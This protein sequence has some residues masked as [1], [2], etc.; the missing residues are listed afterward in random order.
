MSTDTIACLGTHSTQGWHRCTGGCA[1]HS[2]SPH[3]NNTVRG[4][5]KPHY[6]PILVLLDTCNGT[7]NPGKL[8]SFLQTDGVFHGTRVFLI[9]TIVQAGK[10]R[11]ME[12]REAGFPLSSG[13]SVA[14][15]GQKIR[16]LILHSVIH[17]FIHSH[18][19]KAAS[20][21]NLE[22]DLEQCRAQRLPQSHSTP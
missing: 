20:Q 6:S 11:S 13:K 2:Q 18:P 7:A 3:G 1:H 10:L 19:S 5:K 16:L 17:S 21:D 12:V 8:K 9:S 4:S 15:L 14:G 22:A